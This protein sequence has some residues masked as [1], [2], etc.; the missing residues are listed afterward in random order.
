MTGQTQFTGSGRRPKDAQ[1]M[2]P[3]GGKVI[4][5]HNFAT[6]MVQTK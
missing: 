6:K 2:Q 3:S 5:K 4:A 1:G